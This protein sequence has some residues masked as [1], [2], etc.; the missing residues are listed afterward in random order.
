MQNL[1]CKMQNYAAIAFFLSFSLIFID[2]CVAAEKN[3]FQFK[4]QPEIQQVRP[5]KPVK[6]KIH[7]TAK[8]E[9]TWELTGDNVDE[10]ANADRKLRKLLKSE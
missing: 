10:I 6:I 2:R 7:R 3:D 8:G 5:P 9:Y 1:K 4:K